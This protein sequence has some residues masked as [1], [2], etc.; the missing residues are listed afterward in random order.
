MPDF[1]CATCGAAF[2]IPDAVLARYPGWKPRFCRAH[3]QKGG[4]ASGGSGGSGGA[5]RR[6]G[7]GGGSARSG[8]GRSLREENLPVADVM[9]RHSGGPDEGIFTDGSCDPNPGPGGWG[10]VW[11][12]DGEPAVM[13]HGHAPDTT[14]N[15]MEM[16]AVLEALRLVG[17]DDAVTIHS[18]SQLVVKTLTEWSR[19]WE[20]NGWKRKSGPIANLDLVQETWAALQARPKVRLQWV[21]AH[22]GNKWNEVADSLATAWMRERA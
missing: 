5:A 11:V 22:V 3:S 7:G 13:K 8:R 9:A 19:G 1:Q 15:R 12:K 21:R 16:Q 10:L 20:R 6:G 17:P 4:G 14:N 18:D 2:S